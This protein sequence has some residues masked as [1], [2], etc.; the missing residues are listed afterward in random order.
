MEA[1]T[2][3]GE[4]L[5]FFFRCLEP[6]AAHLKTISGVDPMNVQKTILESHQISQ[7][8]L[9][10]V[11]SAV[12]GRTN[13]RGDD[14]HP[15]SPGPWDPVIRRALERVTSFG[16]HPEPWLRSSELAKLVLA[17]VAS[18]RPEIF[19]AIKPHSLIELVELNPQPLP[20]R[21][22]FLASLAR[23]IIDRA[24]FMQEF[25]QSIRSQGEE[26]GIII[27]S[28]YLSRFADDL[29]PD[30]FRLKWPFGKPR[31]HWFDEKLDGVDLLTLAAQFDQ[32]AKEAFSP[33]LRQG[34]AD[35]S[36]KFA[37]SGLSRMQ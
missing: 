35:A 11:A 17:F 27:V 28:G 21:Q 22:A 33:A 30:I 18:L 4:L 15:L 26:Q 25:A 34:L 24:E 32:A 13:G 3:D 10:A 6:P 16:P 7:E 23:I 37:E 2:C 31:P 14:D 12:A 20:P 8:T 29:C 1:K 19:D 36:I 9:L 5:C